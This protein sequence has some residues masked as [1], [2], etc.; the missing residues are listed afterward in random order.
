MRLKLCWSKTPASVIEVQTRKQRGARS[1]PDFGFY[2]A[3]S[4]EQ[5][6]AYTGSSLNDA[7]CPID[8]NT[9]E[10][11]YSQGA[12]EVDGNQYRQLYEECEALRNEKNKLSHALYEMEVHSEVLVSQCSQIV[13]Q[14]NEKL[15]EALGAVSE[16]NGIVK[17]LK[18]ES[19]KHLNTIS[20]LKMEKSILNNRLEAVLNELH[21]ATGSTAFTV[22]EKLR[23]TPQH[24]YGSITLDSSSQE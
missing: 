7:V 10:T 12:Q 16:L 20:D 14:N 3:E 1:R 2:E 22:K 24:P 23:I 17:Y 19:E 8:E 5:E 21:K 6:A 13:K 18:K 15:S 4:P 9:S 11:L